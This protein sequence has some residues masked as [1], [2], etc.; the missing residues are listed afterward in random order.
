MAALPGVQ[1]M[2]SLLK[3]ILHRLGVRFWC[4]VAEDGT[5]WDEIT[6]APHLGDPSFPDM[7]PCFLEMIDGHPSGR[8]WS[9]YIHGNTHDGMEVYFSPSGWKRVNPDLSVEWSTV[10]RVAFGR[11]EFQ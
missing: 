2:K 4:Y 1:S 3:K 10:K 9:S 7:E 11:V 6:A 8:F 5:I